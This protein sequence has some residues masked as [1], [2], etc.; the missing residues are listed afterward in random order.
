MD[1][2]YVFMAHATGVLLI[3]LIWFGVREPQFE[4][5]PAAKSAGGKIPW[6]MLAIG[7]A[8]G[9]AINGPTLFISYHLVEVGIKD[10]QLI[11]IALVSSV[12]AG[13]IAAAFFGSLRKRLPAR[14]TFVLSFLCLAVGLTMIGMSQ[15]F[16]MAVAGGW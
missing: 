14:A 4:K 15:N 2:R 6:G 1:W 11:S 9:V 13:A 3:A 8:V 5:G 16:W 7:L 12:I 10:P